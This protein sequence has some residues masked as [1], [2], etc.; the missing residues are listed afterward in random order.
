MSFVRA[1]SIR[2]ARVATPSKGGSDAK[3]LKP[4]VY[5]RGPGGTKPRPT[6]LFGQSVRLVLSIPPPRIPLQARTSR[7]RPVPVD[8]LVL[9]MSVP[10]LTAT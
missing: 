7:N 3:H 4:I 10:C 9:F 2:T 6:E 5:A 8:G 1:L